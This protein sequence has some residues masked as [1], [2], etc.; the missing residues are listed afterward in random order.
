MNR[1]GIRLRFKNSSMTAVPSIHFRVPFAM[2]V[3]RLC[4]NGK[5]SPD[6]IA[7]EMETE[8]ASAALAWIRELTVDNDTFKALPVMLGLVQNST[9]SQNPDT[10]RPAAERDQFIRENPPGAFLKRP[11]PAGVKVLYLS[12]ADSIV[13][14][15]RCAIESDIPLY[16]VDSEKMPRSR[17]PGPVLEDPAVMHGDMVR[18][19]KA[20]VR[21][22]DASRDNV[23]DHARE[24]AMTARLKTILGRHKRVL[25]VCGLAHWARIKKLLNDPSVLAEP[26]TEC[27]PRPDTREITRTVIHP[28][29]AVN[30][31][32]LFP[33]MVRLYEQQR[34]PATGA[35]AA[36]RQKHQ[37]KPHEV[38]VRLLNKVYSCRFMLKKA[39]PAPSGCSSDL[40]FLGSF[41]TM[42]ANLR[43]LHLRSTPDFTMA[44]S[45]ANSSMSLGFSKE[46]LKTFLDFPWLKPEDFPQCPVLAPSP[47]SSSNAIRAHWKGMAK[48]DFTIE[49]L[50][51]FSMSGYYNVWGD[52]TDEEQTASAEDT[53]KETLFTWSPWDY[54]MASLSIEAIRKSR[55]RRP[56]TES[57]HFEG[58][59]DDGID[60]RNTLRSFIRDENKLYVHDHVNER[61]RNAPRPPAGFPVVW[62]FSNHAST[63]ADWHILRLHLGY[64]LP[65][66]RNAERMR[67]TIAKSGRNY[68]G[69]IGFGHNDDSLTYESGDRVVVQSR[70]DG[71][72]QYCPLFWNTR[73]FAY[74]MEITEFKSC[75]FYDT[76]NRAAG[77][78]ET[79][80]RKY[81]LSENGREW[82]SDMLLLALPFAQDTLTVVAPD[83]YTI[84]GWISQK[85]S[86]LGIAICKLPLSS[87]PREQV[88]RAR[89]GQLAPLLQ[90]EPDCVHPDW[91]GEFLGEPQNKYRDLVPKEWRNFGLE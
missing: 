57:R 4:S 38:F 73:Q 88:D 75:P 7:V 66:S 53:I 65:Y 15:I 9:R 51:P 59:L 20:N 82:A 87:F 23:V 10:P 68:I 40:H 14:A 47:P 44:M 25:F 28:L 16:A 6:A 13:E 12:P 67:A 17:E 49:S 3:N 63:D 48:E 45:A 54:L 8:F 50:F 52:I 56:R 91:V 24:I 36:G 30:S 35:R 21:N 61:V 41:E 29:L 1:A 11:R 69:G 39:G 46:L 79:L 22:A 86:S 83:E 26:W 60:I 74:W 71:F 90:L 84:P 55:K 77:L 89:I 19:V 43:T 5:G 18:Y 58:S 37:Y 42:L 62:I 33:E 85:A 72:L 78:P 76:C 64:L 80:A 34:R 31:M 70:H 32:D 81:G 2:A 27:V